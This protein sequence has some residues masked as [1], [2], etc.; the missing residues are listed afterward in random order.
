MAHGTTAHLVTN[1]N[2]VRPTTTSAWHHSFVT[3]HSP[4]ATH[5]NES[6]C[7]SQSNRSNIRSLASGSRYKFRHIHSVYDLLILLFESIVARQLSQRETRVR[8]LNI[9]QVSEYE[10][11]NRTIRKGKTNSK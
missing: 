11:S 3:G 10:I 2:I 6:I 5:K 1:N 7:A 4:F 9:V 8:I